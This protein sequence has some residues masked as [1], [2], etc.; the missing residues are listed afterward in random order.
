MEVLYEHCAGLDVHKKTV[1]A[2]RVFTPTAGRKQQETRTFGTTTRELLLLLNW[3][4]EFGCTHVAM[5]S[6]G[7]YWKPVYNLLEGFFELLL[8]NP[9]HIKNVPGRKTDV[10]DAAWLAD[11][12]R[13]GLVRGSFVPSRPQRELRDLTRGRSNL[14]GERNRLVNRVQKV[15]EDANIKLGNVAS[16]IM[17]VSG[18][19]M[20]E[21]LCRGVTDPEA[22]AE[23][24]R[25]SLR[26]KREALAEA[27]EGRVNAH[28]R[29]LLTQHLEHLGFIESQIAHFDQELE[30]RIAQLSVRPQGAPAGGTEL[31]APAEEARNG[32][33][34]LPPQEPP[35]YAR[36]VELV[37]PIP[38]IGVRAAQA[39]LAEMGVDMR[40]FP[41]AAQLTSWA[42]VSPGNRQSAGKRLS[43]KT[44]YGNVWLRKAL[45]QAA[46]GACR[47]KGTSFKALY[48]RI[49]GRRGKKRAIVAVARQIL[50]VI[51]H[52][53]LYQEPYRELG[54]VYLDERQR[55]VTIKHLTKRLQKLGCNITLSAV[56]A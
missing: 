49:A 36:A 37:M 41:S 18:R 39:V 34:G 5:E 22:L 4:Q 52:V 48:H 19:A 20:L 3:L 27:L 43:G 26:Q 17:G 54:D 11:L 8:V 21:A 31:R 53:L 32:Q 33:R 30:E 12:L 50:V 23:L 24:A 44:T 16:D 9:Q 29:F 42:G 45:V 7:E 2:C 35:T 28:H 38:G 55:E 14:V 15:L 47:A 46:H 40:R 25:G 51:Y 6:T 10:K 1:V 13:H 56:A